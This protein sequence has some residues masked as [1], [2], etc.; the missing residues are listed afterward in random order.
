MSYRS[1]VDTNGLVVIEDPAVIAHSLPGDDGGPLLVVG[2]QSDMTKQWAA[3]YA[4]FLSNVGDGPP[5][6]PIAGLQFFHSQDRALFVFDGLPVGQVVWDGTGWQWSS[7][8]QRGARL[9]LESIEVDPDQYATFTKERQQNA[10]CDESLIP[11]LMAELNGRVALWRDETRDLAFM[12]GKSRARRR[13][14]HRR[15]QQV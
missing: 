3:W 10:L 12:Y 13:G 2:T 14:L 15:S 4:E 8:D 5:P 9:D 6:W 1:R 11:V 7:L